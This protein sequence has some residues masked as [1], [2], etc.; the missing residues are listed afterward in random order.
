VIFNRIIPSSRSSYTRETREG[1]P[2]M[3]VETKTNG[4]L[5]SI[6]RV[7]PWLVRWARRAGT[8]CF[9]PASAALISPVQNIFL[10]AHL[11]VQGRRSLNTCL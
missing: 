6:K 9:Y 2:L 8:R 7:L 10:T 11:V 3:T 1:W 4:D 5:W